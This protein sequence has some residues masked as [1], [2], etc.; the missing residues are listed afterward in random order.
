MLTDQITTGRKGF[1]HGRYIKRKNR[2]FVGESTEF[3]CNP[4]NKKYKIQD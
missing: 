4:S 3:F 2:K 1:N